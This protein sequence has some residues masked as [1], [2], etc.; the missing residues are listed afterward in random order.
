MNGFTERRASGAERSGS[1][2]RVLTWGASH[3][4]LPLAGRIAADI[5]RYEE[6]RA[7]LQPEMARLDRLRHTLDWPRRSRRYQ[8]QEEIAAVEANLRQA[9]AE[10]EG[11]GLTL[12]HLP[13]GL[14]GFPTLVNNRRA[15]FS[16][17]P[18]E[19]SLAF[20]NY[21]GDDVRRPVPAAWTK[22][23]KARARR[24]KSKPKE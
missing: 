21:A 3:A 16:W 9:Q 10:L 11:L 6:Q 24:G 15:F 22:P 1:S 12:L 4:M 20:W 14:I 17:Q 23:P 8:L 2:D 5:V 19:E 7:R 13:S 18:G